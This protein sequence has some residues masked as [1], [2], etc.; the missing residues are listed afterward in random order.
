MPWM[1]DIQAS[2]TFNASCAMPFSRSTL[3]TR[4]LISPAALRVKVMAKM[5][6]TPSTAG[7]LS[8]ER[9]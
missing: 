3:R 2:S 1:V 8:G 4:L 5:R 7:P 9:A 6:S